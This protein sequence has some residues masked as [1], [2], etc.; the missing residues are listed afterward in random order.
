MKLGLPAATG[1]IGSAA[2]AG[3]DVATPRAS[4]PA[5]MM[6]VKGD[7]GILKLPPRDVRGESLQGKYSAR[8]RTVFLNLKR[9][10]HS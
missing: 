1:A 9:M 2:L 10:L 4:A 5:A 6:V 7:F 3:S 8:Y